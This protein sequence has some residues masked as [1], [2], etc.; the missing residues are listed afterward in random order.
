MSSEKVIPKEKVDPDT[1]LDLTNISSCKNL[2]SMRAEKDALLTSDLLLKVKRLT[3]LYCDP[4]KTWSCQLLEVLAPNLEEVHLHNFHLKHL[5]VVQRMPELR[6]LVLDNLSDKIQNVGKENY[7]LPPLQHQSKVEFFWCNV[8]G[9]KNQKLCSDIIKAHA[10]SV[11]VL[12]TVTPY[13]HQLEK[14]DELN[15]SNLTSLFYLN[16]YCG[17]GSCKE[18]MDVLRDRYPKLNVFCFKCGRTNTYDE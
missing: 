10:S 6:W 17:N 18:K 5:E 15:I 1:V 2:E 7:E 4:D 14:F 16:D 8:S 11:K 9:G 12:L 13:H 3:G